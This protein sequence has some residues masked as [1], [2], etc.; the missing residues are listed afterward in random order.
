MTNGL[1]AILACIIVNVLAQLV[2]ISDI[3]RRLDKL[4]GKRK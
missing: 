4:E 3:K 1:A 2:I